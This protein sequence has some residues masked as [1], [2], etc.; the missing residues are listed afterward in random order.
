MLRLQCLSELVDLSTVDQACIKVGLDFF[1]VAALQVVVGDV[2]EVLLP[3]LEESD[4]A[5]KTLG[6]TTRK[7]C[8]TTRC[9]ASTSA[10]EATAATK[11]G[12]S[13]YATKTASTLPRESRQTCA[14]QEPTPSAWATGPAANRNVRV[15]T[16]AIALERTQIAKHG[17]FGD[18][19]GLQCDD[20]PTV[21]QQGLDQVEACK[22]KSGAGVGTGKLPDKRVGKVGRQRAGSGETA[23]ERRVGSGGQRRGGTGTLCGDIGV[24]ATKKL[25][26]ETKSF[27][28]DIKCR[29]V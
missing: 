10:G 27:C 13:T 1:K 26:L 24:I 16:L 14:A 7:T 21:A 9:T 4:E 11:V 2:V 25:G 15:K 28:A 6:T 8:G 12:G 19:Q 3:L 17:S 23:I 5:S 18:R 29:Q 22:R 20:T